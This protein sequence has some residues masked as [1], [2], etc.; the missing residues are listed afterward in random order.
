MVPAAGVSLVEWVVGGLGGAVVGV[1]VVA[2]RVR[3]VTALSPRR[4]GTR[5]M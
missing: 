2:V 5:L 1:V 3:G 4:A